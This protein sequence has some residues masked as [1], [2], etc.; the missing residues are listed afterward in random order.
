MIQ[1]EAD[2]DFFRSIDTPEK[3]YTLGFMATDGHVAENGMVLSLQKGDRTV[4]ERIRGWMHSSH[5]ITERPMSRSTGTQAT[6]KVYGSEIVRDL[7]LLGF[8][9]NKTF[10]I[11]PW[12]GPSELLPHY[13]RGCVDGDGW[14]ID[15]G[16]NFT[17]GFCGNIHMVTGF[18]DYIENTT[19][20]RANIRSHKS[21]FRVEYS[22]VRPAQRAIRAL[23]YSDY[24]EICLPRKHTL[25]LKVL[26][27][28]FR[29]NGSSTKGKKY[30]EAHNLANSRR[31]GGTA[32]RDQNGIV[33]STAASAARALGIQRSHVSSV[34]SGRRK[35]VGG[36]SFVR[37]QDG[38]MGQA[39]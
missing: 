24:P 32:I 37:V 12:T 20:H 4:L 30:D 31:Q 29:P 16:S 25:A 22:G 19:Q 6:L 11:S 33:Y 5:K 35:T 13:W 23:K 28:K 15:R 17:V 39:Q 21:I 38:S 7:R 34:L 10:T 2:R 36:Y 1:Y 18:R 3:A 8:S 26:E 9:N 27:A 14:V